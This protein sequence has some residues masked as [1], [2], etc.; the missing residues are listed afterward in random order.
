MPIRHQAT[1]SLSER[2]SEHCLLL[3][4]LLDSTPKT[5]AG[6]LMLGQVRWG[7]GSHTMPAA[8]HQATEHVIAS[9]VTSACATQ[10]RGKARRARHCHGAIHVIRRLGR[11]QIHSSCSPAVQ[12]DSRARCGRRPS[13]GGD[14]PARATQPLPP[15]VPQLQHAQ[16]ASLPCIAP[17]S[18]GAKGL[19]LSA[20]VASAP[21]A[22]S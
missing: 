6:S 17:C 5:T 10:Q 16:P 20:C 19:T 22:M 14:P 2:V 21:A 7:A 9:C 1:H 15:N 18:D 4:N 3:T 13:L 12:P 11:P 8:R